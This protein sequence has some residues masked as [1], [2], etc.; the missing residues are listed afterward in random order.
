MLLLVLTWLFT[1]CSKQSSEEM[2]EESSPSFSFFKLDLEDRSVSPVS[3]QSM[4]ANKTFEKSISTRNPNSSTNGIY[5]TPSGS[6]CEFSAMQN[7]SGTHGDSEIVLWGGEYTIQ[8]NSDCLS[9]NGNQAFFGG[10][11]TS[12]EV[13]DGAR[14]LAGGVGWSIFIGVEDGG[15][16][17][18]ANPDKFGRVLYLAAPGTTPADE[19]YPQFDNWCDFWNAA[20]N[21]LG[22]PL[23][24]YFIDGE[25]PTNVQVNE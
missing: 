4:L 8:F 20:Y 17:N 12:F 13:A 19:G 24:Y 15:E 9:T 10:E 21:G 22:N 18:N 1:G 6:T 5:N 7:K 25:H 2:I 14:D 16:G 23:F 3:L 11:I